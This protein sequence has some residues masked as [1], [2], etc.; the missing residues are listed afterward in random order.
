MRVLVP[1]GYYVGNDVIDPREYDFTD[2]RNEENISLNS[3][4]R[5]S[6]PD[7]TYVNDL[8]N[9]P[10]AEYVEKYTRI[11][12]KDKHHRL[13]DIIEAKFNMMMYSLLG[14]HD[15]KFKIT[16]SWITRLNKGDE[17][18]AHRHHNCYYSGVLYF[19]EDY[20]DAA[21]LTLRNPIATNSYIHFSTAQDNG[22]MMHGDFT[23]NAYTGG[24]YFWPSQFEHSTGVSRVNNR[25]S[26]AF[27]LVPTQ[28]IYS[29]DSSLSVDWLSP[30]KSHN[31]INDTNDYPT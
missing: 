24:L 7:S 14:N 15:Y 30:A 3:I 5:D 23:I 21:N 12:A 2:L 10:P 1:F 9:L 25:S 13:R 18:Q 8:Q 6:Y 26:L 28:A 29:A 27:N 20:T 17:I 31:L 22:N 11:L 19:G 4:Q 16:T